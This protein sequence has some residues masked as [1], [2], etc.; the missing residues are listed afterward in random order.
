MD[1]MECLID[2][3]TWSSMLLREREYLCKQSC[4]MSLD[5]ILKPMN[6]AIILARK[7][8]ALKNYHNYLGGK[9]QLESFEVGF[10]EVE[11]HA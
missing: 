7:I 10:M 4:G 2:L 5:G 6:Q 3:G 9:N 11:M 1:A 8:W